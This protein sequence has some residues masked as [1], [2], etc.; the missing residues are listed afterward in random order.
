MRRAKR[1]AARAVQKVAE[2]VMTAATVITWV[3]CACVAVGVPVTTPVVLF[4]VRPAGKAGEMLKVLVPVT[5]LAV[6][7]LVAA[8]AVPT[9]PEMVC[10]AGTIAGVSAIVTQMVALAKLVPSAAVTT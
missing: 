1:E 4:N 8:I 2:A 10:V 7:V 5:V 9:V 6:K 3:A